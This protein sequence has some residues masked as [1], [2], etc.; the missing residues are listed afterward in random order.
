[1]DNLRL[2]AEIEQI[3]YNC[4]DSYA[5][6]LPSPLANVDPASCADDDQM[7]INPLELNDVLETETNEFGEIFFKCPIC[8]RCFRKRWNCTEHLRT[9]SEER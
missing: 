5:N 1:M 4:S 8:G 7:V 9:H 3:N 6:G 2:V